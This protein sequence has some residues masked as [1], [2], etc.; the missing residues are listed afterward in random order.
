MAELKVITD[1]REWQEYCISLGRG[2]STSWRTGG[3]IAAPGPGSSMEPGAGSSIG[4]EPGS[5]IEPTPVA[6]GGHNPHPLRAGVSGSGSSSPAL[7]GLP[8]VGFVP[9]MGAL[10]PGHASLIRR[11]LAENEVTLVSIFVNPTQFNDP[12]DLHDYPRTWDADRA[13]LE[14]LGVDAVFLPRAEQMYSRDFR[15]EVREAG[16]LRAGDDSGFPGDSPGGR[17][18]TGTGDQGEAPAAPEPPASSRQ[19]GGLTSPDNQ[20]LLRLEEPEGSRFSTQ[21]C[22]ASRPGHFEGV[23]TV[24]LK[25]LVLTA[26]SRAYFGEKDYQ[27]YLL[28]RRMAEDFFLPTE[29]VP[30][31][32]VRETSGLAM[33]SRNRLLSP[34]GLERARELYPILRG[35]K[36]APRAVRELEQLGFQVDYLVDRR[37]LGPGEPAR[38]FAAVVLEGIRLIDNLVLEEGA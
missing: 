28:I 14:S 36:D 15:F 2:H 16:I 30:C 12:K 26:P 18:L 7:R 1:P 27:Q 13:L 29:I 33:S 9:T 23:L 3:T 6:P 25:L 31:P 35:S 8:S 38:R 17:R 34:R 19:G 32:V 20:G 10:H 11:S 37:D 22:G 24:V 21:L 4:P 5:S